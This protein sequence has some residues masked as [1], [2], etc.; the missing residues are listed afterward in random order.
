MTGPLR[1]LAFSLAACMIASPG[2]LR[3]AGQSGP[4]RA[5]LRGAGSTFAA[6]LYRDWIAEFRSRN[7]S[8]L[9]DY[10]EVA[11]KAGIDLAR[12][13]KVDFGGSDIAPSQLQAGATDNVLE[14]AAA[15]SAVAPMY[16]VLDDSG[17]VVRGLRFSCKTLAGIFN[18]NIRFWNDPVIER[19]NRDIAGQ[20][21]TRNNEIRVVYRNDPSGTTFLFTTFLSNCGYEGTPGFE[22]SRPPSGSIGA[23]YSDG[24]VGTVELV[25]NAIGY[26]EYNHAA[27]Q[28]VDW[29]A[30][31]NRWG[32]NHPASGG[33]ELARVMS[34]RE[35]ETGLL[36]GSLFDSDAQHAYPISAVTWLLIPVP[37]G[38]AAKDPLCE[39]LNYALEEKEGQKEA[40]SAGYAELP[41]LTLKKQQESVSVICHNIRWKPIGID[42]R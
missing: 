15:A 41:E 19:E 20:L 26:V 34:I 39:F 35:A 23:D 9:I 36:R 30:V 27:S 16:H 42:L 18:G 1:I 22:F 6:P 11:S 21:P 32:L 2:C 7:S 31:Q 10:E 4:R 14:I 8:L 37:L 3:R 25:A 13:H 24:V 5:D 12:K 33:F 40:P 28:N 29:G 17:Y 38:E